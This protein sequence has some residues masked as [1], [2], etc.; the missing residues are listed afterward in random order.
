MDAAFFSSSISDMKRFFFSESNHAR[1]YAIGYC[2]AFF[3]L[4]LVSCKP[5]QNVSIIKSLPKD[6]TVTGYVPSVI[7]SKIRKNDMLGINVSSM[8]AEMDAVFNTS[9]KLASPNE[10]LSNTLGGH[11][12]DAMGNVSLHF[13]GEVR[14]EG[15][16]LR[17]LKQKLEKELMPFLKDPIVSIQYMNRKI[18][19]IGEVNNPHVIYMNAEQMPLF[20][21]LA[22]VGDMKEFA[23][24]KDVMIIRDSGDMKQIKHLNLEQHELLSSSWSYLQPNDLVYLSKDIEKSDKNNRMRNVQST[25][26]LV[27][28]LVSLV[29]IIINNIIK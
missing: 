28:S 10:K 14:A 1:R 12:V 21:A 26:S 29:V 13:I 18:T 17:E 24:L 3:I 23:N 15:L 20:D 9:G 2:V 25:I 4:I 8:N 22:S 5:T 16:T 6:T 27:A 11:L 7:E 19:L